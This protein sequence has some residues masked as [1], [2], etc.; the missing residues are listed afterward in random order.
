VPLCLC[1]VALAVLGTVV[2]RRSPDRSKAAH[3]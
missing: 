3:G 1:A 2:T